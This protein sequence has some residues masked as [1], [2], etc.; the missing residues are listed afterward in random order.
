M[1]EEIILHEKVKLIEKELVTLT[2]KLDSVKNA[3]KDVDEL[4]KE[5]QGLK[6]FFG[7]THPEFKSKFPEIM[8]KLYKK[9]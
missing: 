5:I 3:L 4:K 2:D 9:S 7:R 6:L 8:E 1:K